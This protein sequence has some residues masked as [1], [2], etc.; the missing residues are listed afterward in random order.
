[1]DFEQI[2]KYW[3]WF[4][5]GI[6]T[7]GALVLL[8]GVVTF[9]FAFFKFS[10]FKALRLFRNRQRPI[11]IF[12][13]KS[14]DM[15]V[16]T[17]LLRD[18]K[19]FNIPEDPTDKLQDTNRI[20]NHCLVIIGFSPAMKDFDQIYEGVQRFGVPV[21]IYS[22]RSIPAK[23][24]K[25]IKKYPWYSVCQVPLRLLNDVFTVLS[26]FPEKKKKET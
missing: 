5:Y 10:F 25:T 24:L 17:K 18:C 20:T 16:E 26:T 9:G 12:K 7:H 23:V 1:M 14:E 13:S 8:A 2:K 21:I 6:E 11:M 15:E 19:L 22:K 3:D 4:L